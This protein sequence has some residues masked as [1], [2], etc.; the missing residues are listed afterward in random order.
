MLMIERHDRTGSAESATSAERLLSARPAQA[1]AWDG[2]QG[3]PGDGLRSSRIP[4][5]LLIDDSLLMLTADESSPR[6]DIPPETLNARSCRALVKSKPIAGAISVARCA[7]MMIE[8][9]SRCATTATAGLCS[10]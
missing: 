7:G 9:N 2:Y 6:G 8:I 5:N 3:R 4:D 1:L 10:Q